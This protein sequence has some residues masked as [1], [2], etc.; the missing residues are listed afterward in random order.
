MMVNGISGILVCSIVLLAL[1]DC[2]AVQEYLPTPVPAFVPDSNSILMPTTIENPVTSKAS[3]AQEDKEESIAG[4]EFTLD[5][6]IQWALKADPQ[7]QAGLENIHQAKADLMTA[8]L[9]PNPN[10]YANEELVPV[11]FSRPFSPTHEGGPPQLNALVQF[12]VDWFL[13]GKRAAAVVAAQR[14]V[15]VAAADFAE[16]I[17]QRISGTITAFYD[18]LEAEAMVE[19][20]KEDLSNLS[21]MKTIIT[22]RVKIGGIATIELDRIRLSIFSSQRELQAVGL[23]LAAARNRLCVF[24]GFEDPIPLRVRGD[25]KVTHPAAPISTE[26]AIALAEENRPDFIAKQRQIV[27]VA[28]KVKSEKKQAYPE[29]SPFLGYSRQFQQQAMGVPDANSWNF[30]IQMEM[31]LFDRNQGNIAKMKSALIQSKLNFKAQ[32]VALR[33][34]IDQS[35]RNYRTIYQIITTEDPGQLKAARDVRDK[36]QASYKLGGKSLI[37][38]LDAR[39]TYLETYRIHIASRSGYWH[40]LYALNAAI[41]KQVLK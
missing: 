38:V 12:P 34:E 23:V 8:G 40:S 28:A 16:L 26:V 22:N 19:L 39:R 17:R 7:I 36:I 41:G 20:A 11:P 9:V 10:F 4:Q 25:L 15:D 31:P 3:S 2:G 14:G 18:V 24:L 5:T 30:G 37:E 33:A 1:A 6:A 21:K 35:V 27:E 32:L 13:F 29:I